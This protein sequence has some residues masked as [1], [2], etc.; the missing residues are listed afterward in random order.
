MPRRAAPGSSRSAA[1]AGTSAA[2]S[3]A[4]CVDG[5]AARQTV[6]HD[7]HQIAARTGEAAATRRAATRLDPPACGRDRAA[8]EI[9]PATAR[10]FPRKSPP[11]ERTQ[12]RG[13]SRGVERREHGVPRTGVGQTEIQQRARRQAAARAA[14]ARCAPPSDAAG[15]ARDRAMD[16]PWM[17]ASDALA[18]NSASCGA[19]S[20]CRALAGSRRRHRR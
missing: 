5:G 7:D 2:R 11:A 12:P 16:R 14:R 6:G 20:A 10:R 15:D 17:H 3:G 13:E 19:T 9:R 1:P 18:L 8:A 4:A